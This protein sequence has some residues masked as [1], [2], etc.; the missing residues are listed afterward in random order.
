M[1]EG[2]CGA[3]NG[4]LAEFVISHHLVARLKP[5]QITYTEIYI[6]F[7]WIQVCARGVKLC[8]QGLVDCARLYKCDAD[9]RMLHCKRIPIQTQC[10]LQDIRNSSWRC[11]CI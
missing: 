6:V 7:G 8:F 4:L 11:H 5:R 2:A 9:R 1:N 3:V 10:G